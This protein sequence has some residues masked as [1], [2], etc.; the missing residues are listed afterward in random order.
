MKE[1]FLSLINQDDDLQVAIRCHLVI[2]YYLIKIIEIKLVIPNEFDIDRLT[3]KQKVEL[4]ISLKGIQ[5]EKKGLLLYINKL[6]NKYAHD[7]DHKV[8]DKEISE[9]HSML[10]QD[11]KDQLS[12]TAYSSTN[13]ARKLGGIYLMLY[14]YLKTLH[15]LYEEHP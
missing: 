1:N 6:R 15:E 7:L 11:D 13:N 5:K 4:A 8:T 14:A 10:T 2:E 3:F 9:M 12:K